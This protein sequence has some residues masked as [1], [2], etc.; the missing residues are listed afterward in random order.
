V[1]KPDFMPTRLTL[2]NLILETSAKDTKDDPTFKKLSDE[3]DAL[4]ERFQEEAKLLIKKGIE[5][6]ITMRC[7]KLGRLLLDD[8]RSIAITSAT[9][10]IVY[11]TAIDSEPKCEQPAAL[12]GNLALERI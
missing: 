10:R 7:E 12:L 9:R 1:S 8:M 11:W 4:K 6:R 5:Q 2:R 3:L